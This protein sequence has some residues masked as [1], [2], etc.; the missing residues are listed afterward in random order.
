MLEN[1][2]S[3]PRIQ[4]PAVGFSNILILFPGMTRSSYRSITVFCG[5]EENLALENLPL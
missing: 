2:L 5:S 4:K 3:R 1:R